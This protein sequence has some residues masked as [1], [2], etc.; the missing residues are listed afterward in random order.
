MKV[1]DA[2]TGKAATGAAVIGA[3]LGLTISEWAALATLVFVVLQIIVISP[4]AVH[5]LRE[6]A[7]VFRAWRLKRK[8]PIE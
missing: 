6:Y 3:F 5:Q 8:L 1:Q 2:I 4:K 7:R